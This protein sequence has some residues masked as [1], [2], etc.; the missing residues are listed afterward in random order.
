MKDIGFY[1][2]MVMYIIM[3]IMWIMWIIGFIVGLNWKYRRK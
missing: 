3:W 1:I 2:N